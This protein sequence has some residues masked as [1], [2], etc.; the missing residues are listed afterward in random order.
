MLKKIVVIGFYFSLALSIGGFCGCEDNTEDNTKPQRAKRKPSIQRLRLR[1]GIVA[2]LRDGH[3]RLFFTM[4]D[5]QRVEK[6]AKKQPLL[7]EM[8]IQLKR[9]AERMLDEPI[10]RNH[11]NIHH[12]ILPQSRI[13]LARTLTLSMAYRL[14]SDTRFFE[15]ARKEMLA[16][17]AFETWNPRCFLDVAEMCSALAIGYDWLYDILSA[18]DRLTIRNAI[19]TKALKPGLKAYLNTAKWSWWVKSSNNWNQVCNGGLT[20][21]ALAVAEDEP[22]IAAKVISH[23]LDSIRNG[24]F[25]Y[26]PSGAWYEGSMYWTY[27]TTYN[28]MMIAA[29]DS[30][31]GS[32][33]GLSKAEGFEKTGMFRIY[34]IRPNGLFYN[35]SD[36]ELEPHISPV[37]FWLARKFDSPAYARFEHHLLRQML[38]QQDGYKVNYSIPETRFHALGIAWFDPRGELPTDGKLPLD[39]Y[40]RGKADAVVMRSARDKNALYVGFKGGHSGFGHGHMDIGSFILD[41][42]GVGWAIDLGIENYSLSGCGDYHENGRRW[43]YF[44]M[45]SKGHNTLVIG[46]KLQRVRGSH[47]KIIKYLSTSRRTH[48]VLDMTN[49]YKGQAKKVFRGVAMLD[50]RAVLI[51]DEITAPS[52]EVRWGMLTPARIKLN[53]TKAILTKD[54]KALSVEILEPAGARFEIV[55][56]PPPGKGERARPGISM[57]AVFVKP[58]GGGKKPIRLAVLLTPSGKHWKKVLP[59][60]LRPMDEWKKHARQNDTD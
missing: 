9:D 47:S 58:T 6:L 30:A 48:A 19:V 45:N 22:D 21:G 18:E 20:L 43:N 5:Q 27:G 31:F 49:A 34:T 55:I 57:L 29:L 32:D 14:T 2:N 35:Y 50:R 41:A 44:R 23:A 51:Q 33:F 11:L 24:M 54:G 1:P 7:A 3:P 42:D 15:R 60:K 10:I 4:A 13:C 8:I 52:G 56:P 28:A 59:P 38:T 17:A 37:M 12:S 46:G 53:G 25:S 36:C 40:F 16:A 26:R 39:A